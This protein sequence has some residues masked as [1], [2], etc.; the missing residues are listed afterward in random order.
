VEALERFP[1]PVEADPEGQGPGHMCL[2]RCG[3]ALP[4]G[5]HTCDTLDHAGT[6]H[7]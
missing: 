5:S 1:A 2:R 7:A 3:R 6:K 4:C